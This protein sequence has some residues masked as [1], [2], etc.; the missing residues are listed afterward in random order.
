M[1]EIAGNQPEM[2]NNST[3]EALCGNMNFV[4]W[5]TIIYGGLSC[6]TIIGAIPGVPMIFA[7]LRLTEAAKELRSFLASNDMASIFRALERQNRAFFIAKWYLI[8]SLIFTVLYILFW[9]F[10]GLSYFMNR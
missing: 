5:F 4:G 9:I 3:I 8:V 10:F 2:N 1:N 6:L 7:G